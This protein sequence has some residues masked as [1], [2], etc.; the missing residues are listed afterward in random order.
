[1]HHNNFINFNEI[2][3]QLNGYARVTIFNAEELDGKIDQNSYKIISFTE[4]SILNG[5]PNGFAR[6]LDGKGG[7]KIGFWKSI[8][9]ETDIK[10]DINTIFN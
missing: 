6:Q 5:F 10:S 1:M 4:G 9:V 3:N 2:K 7:C 8:E